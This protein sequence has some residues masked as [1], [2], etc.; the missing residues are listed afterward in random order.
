MK[1]IEWEH[2]SNEYSEHISRTRTMFGWLVIVVNDVMT[3]FSDNR[4]EHG[5]EWR[6]SVTFIFDPF[7]T[8]LK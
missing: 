4:I 2:V 3:H 8:W 5:Y 1:A 7:H 6:S